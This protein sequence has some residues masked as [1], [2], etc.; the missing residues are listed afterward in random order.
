MLVRVSENHVGQRKFRRQHLWDHHLFSK[1]PPGLQK[2]QNMRSFSTNNTGTTH[3]TWQHLCYM[4]VT[5]ML[6]VMTNRDSRLLAPLFYSWEAWDQWVRKVKQGLPVPTANTPE[7]HLYTLK[8][9]YLF[10]HCDWTT[11][12]S[13]VVGGQSVLLESP[14]KAGKSHENIF[15]FKI[16]RAGE[17][18][19]SVKWL[20]C[21]E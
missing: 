15:P 13:N 9:H 2:D 18:H 10:S 14:L 6:T 17:M 20:P 1:R 7:A 19:Q 4:H 21:V 12:G 11:L 8:P 16:S 5:Y 3:F